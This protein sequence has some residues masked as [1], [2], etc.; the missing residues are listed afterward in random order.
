MV[1]VALAPVMVAFA[2]MPA[3]VRFELVPAGVL[4]G[5]GTEIAPEFTVT[6]PGTGGGAEPTDN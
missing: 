3:T 6:V 4:S 2:G 5:I 1:Q